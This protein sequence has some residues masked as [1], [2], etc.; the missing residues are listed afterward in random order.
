ME[1][2]KKKE[3][4]FNAKKVLVTG[5]AGFIGSHLVEALVRQGAHITV[6]DNLSAG[7]WDNLE[8]VRRDVETVTGDVRDAAL[9][10]ELIPGIS[11][12]YLFNLAA[13]ASVPGS[14][15]NPRYDFETNCSGSLLLLDVLR[16]HCPDSRFILSSSAAVYGEPGPHPIREEETPLEPISPYGASKLAAEV[17][18]R[19]FHSV[20]GIPVV[21]GR[22]FNTYGP[23]MPR[24]VVLDFLKKLKR[25]PRSL[26]ILGDGSQTRDFSFVD[27]TV[28]GLMLT[29][30][31]GE[32]GKAYNIA[33]GSSISVDSL[34][35]R[36]LEILQMNSPTDIHNSHKSWVGDARLWNVDISMIK[37]I[38][39]TPHVSLNEGLKRMIHWFESVHGRI[40][41]R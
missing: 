41:G 29:A 18:C 4:P 5:G 23:R 38:G 6:L 30:S 24:F 22:I 26:E 1:E 39:F 31:R 36:L 37:G 40:P 20:Y 16:K 25:N 11:P 33:S 21:I 27:D 2:S 15:E 13:N 28:M 10:E 9:L 14:V 7:T 35:H 32:A 17:E 8:S 19:I 12:R 34:A 3:N